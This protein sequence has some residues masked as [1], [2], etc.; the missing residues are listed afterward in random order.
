MMAGT[1]DDVDF[2]RLASGH[3]SSP[4]KQSHKKSRSLMDTYMKEATEGLSAAS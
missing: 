3:T 1:A 4:T 2:N